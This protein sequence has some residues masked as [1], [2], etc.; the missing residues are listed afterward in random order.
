M[1]FEQE[2]T[3]VTARREEVE[4]AGGVGE[5]LEDWEV[6]TRS[7][8]TRH[9]HVTSVTSVTGPGRKRSMLEVWLDML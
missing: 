1:L 9:Q 2:P 4:A 5:G 7:R 6:A 3:P 8:S